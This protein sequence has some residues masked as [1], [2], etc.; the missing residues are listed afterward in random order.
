MILHQLQIVHRSQH[1]SNVAWEGLEHKKANSEWVLTSSLCLGICGVFWHLDWEP[2]LKPILSKCVF[3]RIIFSKL[4]LSRD[5]IG[6]CLLLCFAIT[7]K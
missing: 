7:L 3:R 6:G 2:Q 1:K 4:N 5:G